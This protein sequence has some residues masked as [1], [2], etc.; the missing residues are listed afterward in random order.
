MS[1]ETARSELLDYLRRQLIGP[2]GSKTEVIVDPPNG[3]YLMGVLFPRAIEFE[4]YVEAEGEQRETNGISRRPGR[5][6]D[7]FGDDPV[8]SSND[9]LPA[10]QGISFFTDSRAITVRTTGA[11]YETL[12]GEKAAAALAAQD[13]NA[14]PTVPQERGGGSRGK[15]RSGRVWQRVPLA[16]DELTIT[17]DSPASQPAL[18]GRAEVN[19]RWRPYAGG[20]LITV[21]L[22]NVAE[23]EESKDLAWD[24]MILQAGL[25][26]TVQDDG[27]IR[28]YP[29]ARLTSSD[30]E[31]VELRLQY[32][33]A[34]T[35]AVGHGTAADWIVSDDGLVRTVSTEVM[36]TQ[37]VPR[38]RAAGTGGNVLS[39]HWLGNASLDAATLNAELGSFV[40]GYRGWVEK[41]RRAVDELETWA[42][43]A[44]DRIVR[45]LEVAVER[46]HAGVELLNDSP[47]AREAFRLANV[48][49]ASQMRHSKSDLGGSRRSR[50]DPV[51]ETVDRA[52]VHW[53]PFQLAFALLALPGLADSG[54]DDRDIVDLIWFPT[55]GGKTEAY[56]LLAAFEIFHR[57][58]LDRVRG[59]GTAV[60]SRYTLS[61]LTTQQFQRAAAIICACED[62]RRDDPTR[63][64]DEPISIGLWVGD[65]TT[66]NRYTTAAE[67]FAELRDDPEPDDRFLLERCPWCGTEILPRT[68]SSDDHDYGVEATDTSFRFFCTRDDCRFHDELPVRVIDDHLYDQPATFLLGTVD[69]FAGL[70]WEPRSGCFFG[71]G[72]KRPP[73]LVIQDELHLLSGPLGTTMGVYEAAIQKLCEEDGR[74]AKVVASTATIRRA[75]AQVLGLFGRPVGLFPPTGLDARNSYFAE[76][77]TER[78][79]RLYVGVMAQGHTSDTATV[80]TGAALL[81][82]PV[83]T[84]IQGPAR[85]GYW[86]LI[87][88]HSSLRELGRTVTIARDDIPARLQSIVT[89][90]PVREVSV[91]ELT[92]NVERSQQPRL[93]ERLTFGPDNPEVID[94]LASTN[95]LSVG[96]D[97]P[98][99]ALM[100][101]NGQPKATAEYIQASSRVG[102]G[103][104]PGLVVSMFRSTRPRDRSHYEGFR[105]YHAALYRYVEPTTVTPYSPPSRRRSLHAAL[106]ILVRHGLGLNRD[107]QAGDVLQHQDA[108]TAYV[109]DLVAM[110]EKVEKRE[111]RATRDYLED[112]VADWYGRAREAERLGRSLYYAYQG[113]GQ[114]NLLK[115]FFRR[116][117]GWDTLRS[118][119]N[120]D[121]SC[122]VTVFRRGRD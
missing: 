112:F 95:M 117:Q 66:P 11:R 100:L 67:S 87:A 45:R 4:S 77:D 61:L 12:E 7:A 34:R 107:A 83:S 111:A 44:G 33:H 30:P 22:V 122:L 46:M 47:S 120:V 2:F 74:P 55:G 48:A 88:Y 37:Q 50:T 8:E 49:M 105:P 119:R 96:V 116:G 79:G 51:P 6:E 56:L 80:H 17:A 98:R 42:K 97:V 73:S 115:D 16:E 21:T 13:E 101:V 52:D 76:P 43:P 24:D 121:R 108:V 35:Y 113:K 15:P 81:Q 14:L 75:P 58:L 65:D 92:S 39:L 72:G 109:D 114:F 38:V 84:N 32:L 106:V 18:E 53:W 41:Q 70:A 9:F 25:S 64:G 85:D 27:T 62:M 19:V 99:L 102:R 5:E 1:T 68:M 40:S 118:M 104:T 110:V 86:T 23:A 54:H 103:D 60:L 82:A 31:E 59:G 20:A 10:S 89:T 71:G 91:E 29:S 36:P 94:L 63:F 90:G 57:R 28:E 93:L 78:P 3:R 69:K 26:I